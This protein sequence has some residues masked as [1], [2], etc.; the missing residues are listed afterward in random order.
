M[1]SLAAA[2]GVEAFALAPDPDDPQLTRCVDGR[3][4]LGQP[5]SLN[6]VV[7]RPL[8]LYLNGTEVVT[9]MTIGDHPELLAL[10]FLLNQNMLAAD[11]AVTAIEHDAEL[12][13]VVVRTRSEA[14]YE[15]KLQRRIRTSGCAQGT[16]FGDIMERFDDTRLD[17]T[18]ELRS[19]WLRSLL[20]QIGRQPSLYQKA[21][22]IHGCVLC[23][24][25]RPLVY[26][27]DVGR[28]NAVD[29]IAGYMHRNGLS[30]HDK[31]FYTT[32][33]LTSEMVIKTV[34]MQI[35]IL[36]SRSGFTAWGVELARRAGLTLIGRAKGL[37]F[38]VLAGAE[39]LV[40]DLALAR[41]PGASS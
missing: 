23:R 22:A 27:E 38:V 3:D 6:V 39:R 1:S 25:D 40:Y 33:R 21:G 35:P 26:M 8:T 31:I 4:Q 19:S 16:V 28:H 15:Q 9:L 41:S 34:H 2:K 24:R 37:R 5:V 17:T 32:G 20:V 18:A 36:V 11:D 29:K 14:R 10:G 7:E 13:V 12:D 30:G